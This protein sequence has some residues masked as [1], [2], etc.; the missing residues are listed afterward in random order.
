MQTKTKKQMLKEAKYQD[1]QT[2]RKEYQGYDLWTAFDVK[3]NLVTFGD[4]NCHYDTAQGFIIDQLVE[5]NSLAK[6]A[7]LIGADGVTDMLGDF[8]AN[9][10]D[11]YGGDYWQQLAVDWFDAQYMG[12]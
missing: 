3:G 9:S 2:E 7:D 12:N 10:S 6:F 1:Q 4:R 11:P 8:F 5:T